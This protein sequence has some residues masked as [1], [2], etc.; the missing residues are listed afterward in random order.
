MLVFSTP[1]LRAAAVSNAAWASSG[2]KSRFARKARSTR[3]AEE[4]QGPLDEPVLPPD[5]LDADLL[6][7]ERGARERDAL[8]ERDAYDGQRPARLQPIHRLIQGGL[9]PA[10]FEARVVAQRPAGLDLPADVGLPGSLSQIA[11]A[12]KA[13]AARSGM[14]SVASD[15]RDPR[16]P[17]GEDDREADRARSQHR[18]AVAGPPARS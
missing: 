10:A 11:P 17:G 8:G 18:Q 5:A 13:A 15:L 1:S 6:A 9:V 12:F 2:L 3:R 4:K 7:P 16:R 14:G